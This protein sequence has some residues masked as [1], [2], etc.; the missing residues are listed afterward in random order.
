M[1]HDRGVEE[2]GSESAAGAGV[3]DP[4]ISGTRNDAK[5][6]I[7]H[8]YF[9]CLSALCHDKTQ[10]SSSD[11]Q[12]SLIK[13]LTS[14]TNSI[15]DASKAHAVCLK[16][17]DE[18]AS[19]LLWPG[20]P[21]SVLPATERVSLMHCRDTLI[22][23]ALLGH[24]YRFQA[25][26]LLLNIN[27][28]QAQ[29]ESI[30]VEA[31][32]FFCAQTESEAREKNHG[33]GS[34]R[35]NAPSSRYE[36]ESARPV[37]VRQAR[38]RGRT[39]GKTVPWTTLRVRKTKL[40]YKAKLTRAFRVVKEEGHRALTRN[41]E[42]SVSCYYKLALAYTADRPLETAAACLPSL[43]RCVDL[44]HGE[45]FGDLKKLPVL[46]QMHLYAALNCILNWVDHNHRQIRLL[47][48]TP[49]VPPAPAHEGDLRCSKCLK[50][51]TFRSSEVKGNPKN[52]DVEFDMDVMRFVSS[53][54]GAPVIGVP[55]GTDSV[56]TCTYSEMKQMYTPCVKC[57]Q[58]IFS[59]ILMDPE[60]LR[61]RC[62]ACAAQ[63]L[64]S[65]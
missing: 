33:V 41:S 8:A 43:A 55:L 1:Q 59:E 29:L 2:C 27:Y 44:V 40:S 42:W 6:A 23:L 20:E 36:A 64:F 52:I 16:V 31:H 30:R 7:Y 10:R 39:S 3:F 50:N 54:C 4:G 21:D 24:F 58:P 49:G 12:K 37:A 45:R 17:W 34:E 53:C 26:S 22:R 38:V 5:V 11:E 60:T 13:M 15:F 61:Y 35:E 51:Q 47:A 18:L 57:A 62:V 25:E 32:R 9:E 48:G 46:S 14:K 63:G 19:S 65:N 28:C 56:N